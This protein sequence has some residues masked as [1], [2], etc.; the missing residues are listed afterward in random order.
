MAG[1]AARH[2]LRHRDICRNDAACGP[3]SGRDRPETRQKP[4]SDKSRSSGGAAA[5]CAAALRQ[6]KQ[7]MDCFFGFH[8]S[9]RKPILRRSLSVTDGLRAKFM[10][11]LHKV[12]HGLL[13]GSGSHDTRWVHAAIVKFSEGRLPPQ[14]VHVMPV[15]QNQ[16]WSYCLANA[17]TLPATFG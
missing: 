10:H 15:R 13:R 5:G 4:P 3:V 9:A 6:K 8:G 7:R 11:N 2:R 12:M 17:A 1:S 14:A 16:A